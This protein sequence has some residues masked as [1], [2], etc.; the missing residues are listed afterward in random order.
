M[1][2]CGE[3]LYEE[4][5]QECKNY[6]CHIARGRMKDK[7]VKIGKSLTEES[8]FIETMVKAFDYF[9]V[10]KKIVECDNEFILKALRKVL[11]R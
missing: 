6:P 11:D 1:V 3:Y 8:E 2:D 4:Q 9:D 10:I 5:C 7:P